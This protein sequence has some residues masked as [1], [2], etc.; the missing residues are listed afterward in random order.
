M[1]HY[2]L[3]HYKICLRLIILL[4]LPFIACNIPETLTA[5]SP[6]VTS[7]RPANTAIPVQTP[8]PT[9]LVWFGPNMGSPDFADLF[10]KPEQWS[11]ARS[12]IN[13]FKFHT[14]NVLVYPCKICGDNTLNSFVEVQA[15]KK[16]TEWGIAIGVDVGAVKEWGCTGTEEFHVAKKPLAT[17]EPTV[18]L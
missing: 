12:Q 15:F 1:N 8:V 11:E 17:F 10:S 6:P 18:G 9:D 7:F 13:V 4:A 3:P 14:Q 5:T 16:L 2:K